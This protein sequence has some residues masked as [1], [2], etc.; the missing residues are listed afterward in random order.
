MEGDERDTASLV[1]SVHK[2]VSFKLEDED[3]VVVDVE[4]PVSTSNGDGHGIASAE[5]NQ[6]A[7]GTV[8]PESLWLDNTLIAHP[9]IGIGYFFMLWYAL[10]SFGFP[11]V[12]FVSKKRGH[13][14]APQLFH[15]ALGGLGVAAAEMGF[16]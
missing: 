9:A 13:R 5:P 2:N 14:G 11:S 3:D 8:E 15:P 12:R 16:A 1:N 7:D 6:E 4:M 10:E